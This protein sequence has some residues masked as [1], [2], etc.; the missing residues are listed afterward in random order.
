MDGFRDYRQ[1]GERFADAVR[2][3][4]PAVSVLDHPSDASP[5]GRRR[6]RPPG[7]LLLRPLAA[8][9]L[10]LVST[11]LLVALGLV[12][13]FSASAMRQYATTGLAVRHR[14]E[15]AM[16][17]SSACR[18]CSSR[19]GCRSGP[20]GRRRT[21]CCST[22]LGLLVLVLFAGK[23]VNGG[24]SWIPLP[25]GF[26]L[27]PAELAKLALAL[28]GADL[29]VRKQKLLD[30]RSH[31]L[32]PLVPVAAVL[33]LIL[34]QPDFGT[35][36]SVGTVVVALL[37]VVGT[38]MR[39]FGALVGA[40]VAAAAFLAV[41]TPHRMERLM[42]FRDPFA[43][44]EDTG[45]QAVQGFYA[46]A[47]GGLFGRGL[48]ASF[49]KWSGGLPEAHTD[50]V[51]A[52]VGE[53]L[54][55]LGTLTVVG[56]F[57]VLVY[58]GIR[59]ATNTDDEF[60]RLA[61]AGVTAWLGCQ[62]IDQHGRPSSGCSDHRASAAAGVLRRLG[63]ARSRWRGSGMLLSGRPARARAPR[64]RSR[65]RPDPAR[66]AAGGA[67]PVRSRRRD[68]APPGRGR[69]PP[70]RPR[71]SVGPPAGRPDAGSAPA[72]VSWRGGGTAG[73]VERPLA[74]ADAL[75]R[76]PGPVTALGTGGGWRPAGA[77]PGYALAEIPRCPLPRRPTV[78]LL[79]VP[80][81]AGRARAAPPRP[82]RPGRRRRGRR[83]SAATSRC[84]ATSPRA[85]AAPVVVH[86]ANAAPASP[87]GRRAPD[88][89]TS[90]RPSRARACAGARSSASRCG[91][92]SRARPA[93]RRAS[94]RATLG[95]PTGP[96]LLVTGGSQG[97][98]RIND[99][100]VARGRR[101]GRRRGAGAARRRAQAGRR[102]ACRPAAA[103]LRH[104]PGAAL[105]DRM[106]LASPP[107]TWWSAGRAR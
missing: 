18:S 60:V 36:V 26:N 51:F 67:R 5:T 49:E 53:E 83:A 9:H 33:V 74:L 94:A 99:A 2:R 91:S 47:S 43:D 14:P 38:P 62:A 7:P 50:Y 71:T 12:M 37:W 54:G 59:V 40:L 44:A 80:G 16:Y 103:D 15:Q 11:L 90:P 78:D 75:V 88:A 48:G 70:R 82:P 81:P 102:R 63:A 58:G 24:R 76:R 85:G 30:Q 4:E 3:G 79:R 19:R 66:A 89:R 86:E 98:Q 56:L 92:R 87:T 34:L 32:V 10:L 73:H 45:Y 68:R 31:L 20:T 64:R 107:P 39:I 97:A 29:L 1:R 77:G 69:P 22:T 42:S 84:P 8:Y 27:Q 46:L 35:A 65:P 52:I 41:T 96:V 93:P 105:R 101:P 72:S 57:A 13:V 23:E 21:R 25:M 95:V 106:D 55:L 6:R 104:P 28:W 61:S 100:V 17:V